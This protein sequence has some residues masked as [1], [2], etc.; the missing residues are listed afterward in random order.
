MHFQI[1]DASGR[2]IP[3]RSQDMFDDDPTPPDV[4]PAEQDTPEE[5]HAFLLRMNELAGHWV[6]GRT[7]PELEVDV[8]GTPLAVGGN[9]PVPNYIAP[10]F[11]TWE[12]LAAANP[13]LTPEDVPNLRLVEDLKEGH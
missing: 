6:E 10:M 2:V 4:V 8:D 11:V 1:S 3:T 7:R 12:Y 9:E 5:R 13:P